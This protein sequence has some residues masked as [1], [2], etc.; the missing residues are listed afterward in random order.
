[1]TPMVKYKS[2]F[3]KILFENPTIEFAYLLGYFWADGYISK[4]NNSMGLEIVETDAEK[5]KDIVLSTGNWKIYKRQRK[6]AKGE[7]KKPI[8][9][10]HITDKELKDFLYKYDF[11]KKSY[12]SPDKILQYLSSD[13]KTFFL[14]GIIDGDGNIYNNPKVGTYQFTVSSGYDQDWRYLSDLFDNLEIKYKIQ[15]VVNKNSR[16]SCIRVANKDGIR[17]IYEVIY[18]DSSLLTFGLDRKVN[19]MKSII[20]DH[21]SYKK[22]VIAY[23]DTSSFTFESISSAALFFDVNIST[24]SGAVN[25][26]QI[27]CKG[28]KWTI[29]GSIDHQNITK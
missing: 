13:L 3:D 25:G 16:Y 7:L 29:S 18:R 6:N 10:L 20:D 14:R 21:I 12:A 24:I 19:V 4:T 23:N 26:R 22:S 28:Y 15:R 2:N 5:I 1:M 27:T 8:N 9:T 11:D 17:K